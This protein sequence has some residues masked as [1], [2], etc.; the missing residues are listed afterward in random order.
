MLQRVECPRCGR[1]MSATAL[2]CGRCR[3]ESRSKSR[4]L[5]PNKLFRWL[6]IIVLLLLN[7]AF[8]VYLY[9]TSYK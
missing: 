4:I 9:W 8:V 3:D 2:Y 7:I 6:Y 1:L 5:T